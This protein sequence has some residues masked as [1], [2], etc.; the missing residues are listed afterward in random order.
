M[1][2]AKQPALL[3]LI[4]LI[5]LVFSGMLE[6]MPA[7]LRSAISALLFFAVSWGFAL[8]LA[9]SREL[10]RTGEQPAA[11]TAG[12]LLVNGALLVSLILL[13]SALP[14][15]V[16]YV[17]VR[18]AW[19]VTEGRKPELL[20]PLKENRAKAIGLKYLSWETALGVAGGSLARYLTGAG[21]SGAPVFHWIALTV[22]AVLIAYRLV[23][24][25]DETVDTLTKA[26]ARGETPG[27]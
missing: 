20:R 8:Y 3:S 16:L 14:G 27:Y 15:L 10:A 17:A 1:K 19:L 7:A 26:P 23:W 12:K 18:M 6:D 11:S 5:P 22:V 4:V 24:K 21:P 13:R 25:T 2:D 9:G